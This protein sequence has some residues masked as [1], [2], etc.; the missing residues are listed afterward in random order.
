[1]LRFPRVPPQP[2]DHQEQTWRKTIQK[3]NDFLGNALC[4]TQVGSILDKITQG[5][6]AFEETDR[7]GDKIVH[8]IPE[9]I[10]DEVLYTLVLLLI[11]LRIFLESC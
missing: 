2:P 8:H 10:K 7:H 11:E 9:V 6:S 4:E 5:M 3:C 1:M